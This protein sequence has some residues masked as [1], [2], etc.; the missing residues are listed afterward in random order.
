LCSRLRSSCSIFAAS[1]RSCA[2]NRR[3]KVA[4]PT[5]SGP[6]NSKVWA[7]RSCRIMRSSARLTC[8]FPQKFSNIVDH[9]FPDLGC[10]S[11]KG[12]AAVDDAKSPGILLCPRH[13]RV[14]HFAM[15]CE[16]LLV[17]PRFGCGAGRVSRLRS[18]KT[19]VHVDI[20]EQSEIG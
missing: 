16:R 20:K 9:A 4:F 15:K 18:G 11:V 13:I 19:R 3:A 14:T 2:A 12:P 5:P 1:P 8:A 6:A 17:H 10:N 7:I